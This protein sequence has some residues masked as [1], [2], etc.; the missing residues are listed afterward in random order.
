[1]SDPLIEY[2]DVDLG[3]RREVVLGSVRLV[4]W[5]GEFLG[6][7][8]PNGSGKTT[9][10][11]SMFRLL[12]PMQGEIVRPNRWLRFGYVPQRQDIDE[13][14]PLTAFE[15]ARMGL[16][17]E[18]GIARRVGRVGRDRVLQCLDRTGV[19]ELVHVLY[20]ELSGG[21]KQRVLIARALVRGAD[22]MLLD[23]PTHD[24]DSDSVDGIMGLIAHLHR[25]NNLTVVLVT[26]VLDLVERYADRIVVL[27]NGK[28]A[29]GGGNGM[30]ARAC[31]GGVY[32]TTHG[33][34]DLH[35]GG[36]WAGTAGG[37]S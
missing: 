4:L 27:K 30:L 10:L 3:Y 22:V 34:A 1:M 23:E 14:F 5:N 13:Q 17:P 29:A 21:Q 37:A 12:T 11:R 9:L 26:H 18:L 7:V 16:Y 15:V 6:V 35:A 2:R 31:T 28:L 33:P 20:R 25:A 32:P 24:I 36:P 8:G 19:S